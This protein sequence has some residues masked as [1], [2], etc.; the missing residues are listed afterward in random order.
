M[1]KILFAWRVMTVAIVFVA[2]GC[3]TTATN[4]KY[5]EAANGYTSGLKA[6]REAL[7][8][9]LSDQVHVRRMLAIQY[10]IKNPTGA[11]QT[12]LDPAHPDEAFARFVCVGIS[13]RG[14]IDD[15]LAY[16]D[17]YANGL[18]TIGTRPDEN[19]TALWA[20]IVS[21]R[22]E[23]GAIAEGAPQP[24]E[25]EDVGQQCEAKVLALTAADGLPIHP[26]EEESLGTIVAFYE[27]LKAV[28]DAVKVV[29]TDL[30]KIADEQARK[31]AF[32]DYV[33]S[34][35]QNVQMALGSASALSER[36]KEYWTQR[37]QVSLMKP[38]ASFS[39]VLAMDPKTDG[40]KIV[41]AA[42]E[43]DAALE[44]YDSLSKQPPPANVLASV[45]QAQKKLEALADGGDAASTEEI[46]AWL[47]AFASELKKIRDDVK[48]VKDSLGNV[49]EP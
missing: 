34:N 13:Q 36:L 26:V 32:T 7:D 9:Q 43:A 28:Y 37:L 8:T 15:Q 39:Q 11:R 45:A 19:P 23:G 29:A 4:D 3:A 38:K 24:S 48:G 44:T 46:V 10:Y 22:G 47:K 16:L 31:K 41:T 20:S 5:S 42:Q 25:K 35:R 14:T 27:G 30:L 18:K 6:A 21:L 17:R 1:N 12:N 2:Q 49:K 33:K 40:L